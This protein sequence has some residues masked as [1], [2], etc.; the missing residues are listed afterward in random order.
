M[1]NRLA[2]ALM[3]LAMV[4]LASNDAIF[5]FLGASL[6]MG[7]VVA[8][9]GV[10]L[11]T[12]L[13]I[14]LLVSGHGIKPRLLT[15]KW[16][17]VRALTEMFATLAF[18]SSLAY[19]PLAV[20]TTLVFTSPIILTAV[21]G[22]L[23]GE[24]VGPWRWLAVL[25]GFV[26][27]L[28]ITWRDADGFDLH[29]L[30]PLAAAIGV[31][32]RDVATRYIPKDIPAASVT[33]TTATV[34]SLAGLLTL[35]LGWK[36]SVAPSEYGLC[37]AAALLVGVSFF[38]SIKAI[39]IGELSL[40]AP[41]Q[42][43]IIICATAYGALIWNEIPSLNAVLGGVIIIGSGLIILWREQASSRRNG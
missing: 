3:A 20:A 30:L 11:C 21:S 6:P 15:E 5:K 13:A 19:V 24:R 4:A 12:G 10:A 18:L 1:N 41:V 29:L 8:I 17:L 39:R 16:C 14:V 36:D 2:I 32:G 34:V 7:Q 33:L 38:C 26:G 28:L 42:Y 37:I 35:F 40:L 23:F 25:A 31:A 22:P 27:V 9:R 43:I